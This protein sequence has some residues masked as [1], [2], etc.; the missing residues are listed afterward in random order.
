M[1]TKFMGLEKQL[2]ESHYASG[3]T[4]IVAEH[5]GVTAPSTYSG[6]TSVLTVTVTNLSPPCDRGRNIHPDSRAFNKV[7]LLAPGSPG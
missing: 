3:T 2:A 7:V 1:L 4:W 6:S 5:D